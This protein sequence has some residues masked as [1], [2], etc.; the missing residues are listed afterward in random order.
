MVAEAA[1]GGLGF[2][3]SGHP[4]GECA[5]EVLVPGSPAVSDCSL[6]AHR[7]SRLSKIGPR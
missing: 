6:R 5:S 3:C 2:V 4:R 7:R 1:V